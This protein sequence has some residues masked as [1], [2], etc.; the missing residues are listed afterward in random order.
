MTNK[1]KRFVRELPK[2]KSATEAALKAGYSRKIAREAASDNL[3]KPHIKAAIAAKEKQLD[4]EAMVDA[5]WIRKQLIENTQLAK[6]AGQY[7]ASNGAVD[8]LSKHTGFYAQ[9]NAQK[10]DATRKL[11]DMLE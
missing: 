11:L 8:M 9:D 10:A 2:S 4:D 3:S 1:Q 6:Q 7:A 5:I